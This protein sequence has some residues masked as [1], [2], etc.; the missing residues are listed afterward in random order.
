MNNTPH[1]IVKKR[2]EN[3]LQLSIE[4]MG[5]PNEMVTVEPTGRTRTA[6]GMGPKRGWDEVVITDENDIGRIG[7]RPWNSKP[8]DCW[9]IWDLGAYGPKED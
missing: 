5:E 9:I 2:T 3:G 8:K 6:S 4:G 7:W 1:M